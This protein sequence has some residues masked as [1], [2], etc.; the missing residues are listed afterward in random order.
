MG[1]LVQNGTEPSALP[2]VDPNARPLAP[3][4]SIKVQRERVG[5]ACRQKMRG[6]FSAHNWGK[7][8]DFKDGVWRGHVLH[9]L[10]PAANWCSLFSDSTGIQCRRC[11]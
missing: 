6:F 8:K 2:F 11:A 10:I 9:L 7:C 5:H 1:K 3:E 4:V